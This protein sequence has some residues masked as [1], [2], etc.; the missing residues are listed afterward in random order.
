MRIGIV[1]IDASVAMNP[2]RAARPAIRPLGVSLLAAGALLLLSATP[3]LSQQAGTPQAS[4]NAPDQSVQH[5]IGFEK[6]KHH[7]KG[8]LT[9]QGKALQFATEKGKA[10]VSIA[11]IKD[12]F[13]NADSK[14]VFGGLG[15]T[16]VK[17]G[18][19]YEGGRFLS[20]FSHRV[21]VL[22]VEYNDADGGYH[23]AIFVLPKGQA[24][25][26]KRELVAQ[27]AHASIPPEEP[28]PKG[29]E[30]KKP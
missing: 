1:L 15:G 21:E 12:V 3:A 5:V 9:V 29:K 22:T 11:S 20:L 19:P 23:G 25:A 13:T 27:G 8:T 18:I 16:I 26:I 2:F 30:E 28:A 4:P 10:E 24:T 17:A 6:I 7:A 14:Q